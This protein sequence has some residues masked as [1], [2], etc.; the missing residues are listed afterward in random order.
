[1]SSLES[2]K[3]IERYKAA[4]TLSKAVNVKLMNPRYPDRSLRR[5][6][7]FYRQFRQHG[8]LAKLWTNRNSLARE[9]G[10]KADLYF[11][12]AFRGCLK[13]GGVCARD[14]PL[15]FLGFLLLNLRL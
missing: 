4:R 11:F 9:N 10:I 15:R 8:L 6:V 14:F 2:N 13:E 3:K 1:M 5:F 12:R 7:F